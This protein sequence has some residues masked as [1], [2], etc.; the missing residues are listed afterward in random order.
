MK[1]NQGET[2]F[3][4]AIVKK[5]KGFVDFVW[6]NSPKA[7]DMNEINNIGETRFALYMQV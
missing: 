3:Y 5:G 1:S 6:Y 4:K 7:I 2:P